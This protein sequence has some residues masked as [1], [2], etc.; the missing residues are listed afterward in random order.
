M[1]YTQRGELASLRYFLTTIL[2]T[3]WLTLGSG[4]RIRDSGYRFTVNHHVPTFNSGRIST[5]GHTVRSS[6]CALLILILPLVMV[7]SIGG[8]APT[9]GD[10]TA[11]AF[12]NPR[13]SF[14]P[15]LIVG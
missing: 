11:I 7:S 5:R 2:G 10:P 12:Y 9:M 4:Y 8:E 14:A 3:W 13:G 15:V 1:E 6:R